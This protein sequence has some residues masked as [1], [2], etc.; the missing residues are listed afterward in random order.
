MTQ[1]TWE[2]L[3]TGLESA[4]TWN[5]EYID[6]MGFERAISYFT[7]AIKEDPTLAEA[8][9]NRAKARLWGIRSKIFNRS[10]LGKC[11]EDIKK[12][13][14]LQPDLPEVHVAMGFYYYYGISEY[15]LSLHSFEKALELS[16][17]NNEYMYYLSLIWRALGNWEK[18]QF[19]INKVF[20]ANPR[21]ALFMINIGFSY[22][23][24]HDFSRA[25]ECQN[26]AIKLIPHWY[27][28]YIHKIKSLTS[29]GNISEARAVVLKAEKK[30]GKEY[31][32]TLAELDLYEGKYS[33][34]IKN[35]EQA[36]EQE[37]SDLFESDGDAYLLKAKIYKHAGNATQA[38]E[39]Y[40][41]AVNYFSNLILFN[42]E[43]NFTYS[44]LGIAYAGNGMSQKALENGQKALKLMNLKTE[45]IYDPY[46]LYDMIQIYAIT[47]DN[48]SAL[49][50][51][52]ELL[53]RKSLFTSELV[54]LDPDMKNL[55]ND[56][57]NHI[58]NP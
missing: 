47:G 37:F 9:A 18:V 48:E 57:D 26:R 51:I 28:P 32:R 21:N 38:K 54:K 17:A 55:I 25:L 8:Y 16:P 4:E 43:D 34:A 2:I 42:P 20:N 11:E 14:E 29:T 23:Y 19:F 22:L 46:I 50:M 33:S 6:S 36:K 31:F 49:N 13:I 1:D 7:E 27:I 12:A 5:R 53:E 39:Y 3:Q 56:T 10:E 15:E 58:I 24:L 45:T 30:T 41:M 35:I 52:I 44:K 40:K